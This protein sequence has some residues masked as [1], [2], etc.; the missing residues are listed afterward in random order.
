MAHVPRGN[1]S[2]DGQT[3]TIMCS[4]ESDNAS[5]HLAHE[6]TTRMDT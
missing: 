5:P 6:A 1:A 4:K 2:R 3:S